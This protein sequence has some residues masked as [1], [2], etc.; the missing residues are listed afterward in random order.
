MQGRAGCAA[1]S[2]DLA[3]EAVD[4]AGRMEA[5][6]IEADLHRLRGDLLLLLSEPQRPEAEV[7]FRRAL[8]IA[9]E[10]DAKLWELRT[11]TSLARMWQDQGRQAEARELLARVY[12]R[13]TEGF[14]TPDLRETEVLLDELSSTPRASRV[15]RR[16]SAGS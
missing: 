14:E 3:S 4:Q 8:A 7:S 2:L 10:Q 11:A 16:R 6:W 12:G 13:F 5:Q 9:G 15:A 1:V